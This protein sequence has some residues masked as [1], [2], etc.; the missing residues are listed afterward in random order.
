MTKKANRDGPG[1]GAGS[2]TLRPTE[3]RYGFTL[4][5]PGD[6]TVSFYVTA[7]LLHG[8]LDLRVTFHG[9]DENLE[10]LSANVFPIVQEALRLVEAKVK[11]EDLVEQEE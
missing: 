11:P 8:E 1:D 3:I 6:R 9:R 2:S 7:S 4:E 10:L 5:I